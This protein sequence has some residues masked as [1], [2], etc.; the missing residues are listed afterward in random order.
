[1]KA[2]LIASY[3][4]K[5][6]YISEYVYE[7]IECGEHFTRCTNAKN[8]NP[9]CGKCYRKH[10]AE[11]QKDRLQKK[12]NEAIIREL[13]LLYKDIH[14]FLKPLI[15]EDWMLDTIDKICEKHIE[16]VKRGESNVL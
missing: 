12:K 6:H 16:N 7:C 9:Y 4:R 3:P 1:M 14:N 10:E 8:I 5:P 11:R 15:S 13:E 2:K